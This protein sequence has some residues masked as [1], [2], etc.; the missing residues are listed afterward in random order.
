MKS[1]P[2]QGGVSAKSHYDHSKDGADQAN[3]EDP[4]KWTDV[5][6]AWFTVIVAIANSIL[7]CLV[8]W[9]IFE[10]RKIAERQAR[11]TKQQ[12]A[13]A[14]DAARSAKKT[15]VDAQRP[16]LTII[17]KVASPLEWSRSFGRITFDLCLKNVGKDPAFDVRV[18]YKSIAWR[19]EEGRLKDRLVEFCLARMESLDAEEYGFVVFPD[20]TPSFSEQVA[21]S[22]FG[23]EEN[24]LGV[25]LVLFVC[26]DYRSNLT[27]AWHQTGKA[28]WGQELDSL[29]RR[30]SLD[31]DRTNPV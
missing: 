15:F 30:Y 21:F 28:F 3:K 9:Q 29:R 1:F 22:C 24:M 27:N 7:T 8:V 10:A 26:V 17:P 5:I 16:W 31:T 13:I 25:R 2:M 12:I 4:P 23:F 19:S 20:A 11:E 14:E 18:G 6:V